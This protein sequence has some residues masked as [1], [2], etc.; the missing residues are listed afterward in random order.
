MNGYDVFNV[1][2][3]IASLV[4]SVMQLIYTIKRK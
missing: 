1:V 3:M 2:Y 4:L